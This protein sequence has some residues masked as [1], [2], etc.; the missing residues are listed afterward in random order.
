MTI[1][2][3][4]SVSPWFQSCMP[5]LCRK[6]FDKNVA[7]EVFV[8]PV[9]VFM[10]EDLSLGRLGGSGSSVL[11]LW[12]FIIKA[13]GVHCITC[14]YLSGAGKPAVLSLTVSFFIQLSQSC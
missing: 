10:E 11:P 6:A 2:T 4:S 9:H 14:I 1:Y 8:A 5:V 3:G 12:R 7:V 13:A